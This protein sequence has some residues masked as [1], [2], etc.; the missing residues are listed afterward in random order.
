M[1]TQNVVEDVVKAVAAA[2]VNSGHNKKSLSEKTGIPYATLNRRLLGRSEFT[3]SELL[4]IADATGTRPS[5]FVPEGF[6]SGT[7]AA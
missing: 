7:E 1:N 3:F 2:I 4:I 6:R 5:Q